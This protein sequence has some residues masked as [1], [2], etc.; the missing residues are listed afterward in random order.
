MGRLTSTLCYCGSTVPQGLEDWL[1]H[2][3]SQKYAR[4]MDV[5]WPPFFLLETAAER[6]NITRFIATKW[7]VQ[8][9]P[10]VRTLKLLLMLT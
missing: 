7:F 2:I 8:F 9:H 4:S 10:H 3:R 5:S 6:S 1:L